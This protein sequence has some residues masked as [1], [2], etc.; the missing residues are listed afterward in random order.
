MVPGNHATRSTGV[1]RHMS[2]PWSP[3]HV[4]CMENPGGNEYPNV[5]LRLR[6]KHAHRCGVRENLSF[7]SR[8]LRL[9]SQDPALT[10]PPTGSLHSMVSLDQV[11]LIV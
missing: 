11:R 2:G 6:V 1:G 5:L 10:T 7:E 9:R 3:F 4:H 8:T